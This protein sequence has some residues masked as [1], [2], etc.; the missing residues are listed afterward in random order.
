[1]SGYPSGTPLPGA[2]PIIVYNRARG[3]AVTPSPS[4]NGVDFTGM[5]MVKVKVKYTWNASLGG[6]DQSE[7][8]ETLISAG[9]KK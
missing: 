2:T 3:P 8:T 5:T 6:R 1:M 7:E 9:T 4:P